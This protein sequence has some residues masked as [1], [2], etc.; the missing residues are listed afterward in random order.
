MPYGYP[1]TMNFNPNWMYTPSTT[2]V[3]NNNWTT[4]SSTHFPQ[5]SPVQIAKV[6]GREGAQ[7]FV[8]P[9]SSSV[10]LLDETDSAIWLKTTDDGGYP[11]LN[12]FYITPAEE[13]EQVQKE[14][15]F[16]TLESRLSS[17]EAQYDQ[18][19]TQYAKIEEK[20]NNGKSYSSSNAKNTSSN[21]NK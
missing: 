15:Q 21:P 11:S 5:Q 20:I 13:V 4:M 16:N 3:P 6:H 8:L 9:P 17:V 1:N 14:N 12:K 7:A 19:K 2:G 10:L 18:L